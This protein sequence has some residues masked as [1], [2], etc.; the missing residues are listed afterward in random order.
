[1]KSLTKTFNDVVLTITHIKENQYKINVSGDAKITKG[2]VGY[3]SDG[4]PI[5]TPNIV[6]NDIF[7]TRAEMKR[8]GTYPVFIN[9][10]PLNLAGIWETENKDK[11]IISFPES[12]F[13]Y[14][15]RRPDC[16]YENTYNE[17]GEIMFTRFKKL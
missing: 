12:D 16:V 17:A 9:K 10:K 2:K 3:Y 15:F 11:I 5:N 7:I 6:G 8:L 14:Y 1:M 4:T 13:Y